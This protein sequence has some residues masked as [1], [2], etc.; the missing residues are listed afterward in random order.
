MLVKNSIFRSYD[1][2]G[3]Y[4]DE[5]NEQ[6][7]EHIG[8]AFG[9]LLVRRGE[10]DCV[11][12]RDNRS[13]SPFLIHS[14]IKGINS[15]GIDTVNIGV[16][17]NPVIHFLTHIPGFGG[18]VNV[19]ASHNPKKFN[20]FKIDF[21]KAIPLH[22]EGLQEMY[23]LITKE[24]YVTGSGLNKDEDLLNFYIEYLRKQFIFNKEVK[25]V[26]DCGNG[27]T[28]LIVPR[29]L[30]ALGCEIIPVDCNLDSSFPHGVPDPENR[31]F[32]KEVQ[33]KV[34]EYKADAGFAFDTDGDRLGVVDE[35]GNYY[36]NDRMLLLYA[37]RMLSRYPGSLVIYDVKSSSIIKEFVTKLGGKTK[38]VAT[39]RANLL[40]EMRK[41]AA[42]G[43]EL[44]G[45]TY[46]GKDYLGFDDGIY[47]V[48]QVLS[49]MR[50][51]RKKL[52][53]LMKNLPV[54]V[55][56]PEIKVDCSDEEKFDVVDKVRDEVL[57]KYEH[58]IAVDGVRVNVTE[59]GWFLVRASNTAAYLSI[60]VEGKD[61]QEVDLLLN[62]VDGLLNKVKHLSVKQTK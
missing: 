27:S 2:R 59:T 34:L 12:G 54:R 30:E 41:G 60:R 32:M 52:S 56:T 1:I 47:S 23:S 7:A 38:M 18:G 33:N 42:L 9:S 45:H 21:E 4:P 39:G 46:F 15:T 24:D 11:V 35:K 22:G 10:K 58:V 17:L 36:E 43:S 62:I 14:L 48:C 19:T 49:I 31:D 3:I 50:D 6:T 55:N 26:I 61:Q 16:T 37:Q 40:E 29:V 28:S 5:L 57:K 51:S 53:E 13:T 8:K 44:S 25:I 20:G